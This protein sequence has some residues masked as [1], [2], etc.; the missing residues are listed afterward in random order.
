LHRHNA[1][2]FLKENTFAGKLIVAESSMAWCFRNGI[3]PDLVVTLDPHPTRIVRWFGDPDLNQEKLQADDYYARQDL[4]P[5]F[6]SQ[7]LER[8]RQLVEL[9]DRN[10]R[11][12][13]IAVASCASEAVVRRAE[14]AGMDVYWWNPMYDDYDLPDSLTRK[15][16]AMNGLPCI[17]AGGN[18]GAAC[19]VIAYAVLGKKRL[20]LVGMDFGYYADTPY[21]QTQYY[22][23]IVA[24]VGKDHLDEVFVWIENPHLGRKHYTDPAYLWYRDSFLE[25][26]A[27]A[28]CETWNCTEGG[29]LFG[30][31]IRWTSPREFLASG[32]CAKAAV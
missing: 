4:D 18:V 16:H 19:W 5:H 23:E 13:P 9:I 25:M 30:P 29:I 32:G 2:Q 12:L 1:A 15:V 26:V 31:G 14:Q 17:N 20:G 27:E 28:D 8:N 22:P 21:E 24:M 10:G 7:A 6:Q 11:G 3:R